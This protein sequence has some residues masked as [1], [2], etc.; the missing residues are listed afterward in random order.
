MWGQAL[1]VSV[2][3]WNVCA[4]TNSV[5]G[6]YRSTT[7]ELAWAVSRQAVASDVV[8]LQEFCTGGTWDLEQGLEFATGRQWTVRSWG[9]TGAD[10]SPY[11]CHPDRNGRPRGAQSVTV[12]VASGQAAFT[13]RRLASPPWYVGRAVL[14]ARLSS[15]KVCGTHLSSGRSDDDHQPGSPYRTRQIRQLLA[16]A[17]P[18]A[19][20]GGDLN[21]QPGHRAIAPLY[22]AFDECDARMRPTHDNGKKLD[23]LFAPKG[24]VVSCRVGLPGDGSDHRPLFVKVAL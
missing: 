6:L 15:V 20:V 11:A 16:E 14:C 1:I 12:A 21:A 3:T 13:T 22:A 17:G 9:L 8:F 23:Y 18:R 24:T 4:G 5:C 2:M 10:G 7:Q 19:I